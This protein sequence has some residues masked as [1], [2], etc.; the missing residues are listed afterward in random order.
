MPRGCDVGGDNNADGGAATG[1]YCGSMLDDAVVWFLV[2]ADTPTS[3]TALF[4]SA[5]H[6]PGKYAGCGSAR[7]GVEPNVFGIG[8]MGDWGIRSTFG[9]MGGI[10]SLGE[11]AMRSVLSPT[12][13]VFSSY[14]GIPERNMSS[15]DSDSTDPL[16]L[17]FRLSE[18]RRDTLKSVARSSSNSLTRHVR[19]EV[20]DIA[21]VAK[22][23]GFLSIVT[24]IM[25]NGG[26]VHM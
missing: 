20:L 21:A 18:L 7:A 23:V 17:C 4:H 22:G 13:Q 5:R 2:L 6:P 16:W 11:L 10:F 19:R 26:L 25:R 24:E 1:A 9:R 15:V 3:S 12:P 8:G 14:F